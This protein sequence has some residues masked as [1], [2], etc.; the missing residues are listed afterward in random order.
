[1]DKLMSNVEW[2]ELIYTEMVKI[3][4]ESKDCYMKTDKCL[5][6]V[7]S[8]A[9]LLQLQVDLD[10]VYAKGRLHLHG[11]RVVQDIH[12]A[13]QNV[14]IINSLSE[15][16]VILVKCF[17]LYQFG[18]LCSIVRSGLVYCSGGL[19]GKY[20]VLAVCQIVHCA[21]GLSFLTAVCLIRQKFVSSGLSSSIAVY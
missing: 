19:L 7:V 14:H 15:S 2:D 4:V 3:V 11:V 13:D 12:E 18:I 20:T 5:S 9:D 10:C 6:E 1:M 21:S 8:S 17:P 16:Q